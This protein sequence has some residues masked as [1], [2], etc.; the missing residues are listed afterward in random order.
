VTLELRSDE[1][2]IDV[3]VLAERPVLLTNTTA[4]IAGFAMFGAYILV[5]RFVES[6]GG[7]PSSVAE[8]LGYGFGASATTTGLYLLPGSILMLFAGPT[9]GLLAWARSGR[10]RSE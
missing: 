3:R 4:L 6:P 1:P 8:R 10:S 5:P 7:L 9:A 2:L